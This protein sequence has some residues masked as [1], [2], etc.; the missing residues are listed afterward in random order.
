MKRLKKILIV[1]GYNVI[2]AWEDLKKLSE[3]NLEYAREKLNYVISEYAQFKGYK[4]IIVYDAYKVKDSV[5]RYEKIKNLEIVFTKEKE[6][7]DTYIER[8]ITE[9]GPKKFLDITVATDDIAEQQVVSGKGGNRIST[10]QLYIE[11]NNAQVKIQE[12]IQKTVKNKRNTLDDFLDKEMI[13][14]LND[15]RKKDL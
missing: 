7:A 2:N 10:R 9:L 13:E 8:Y 6:T 5:T 4:T 15:M 14:K 1:D 3:E 12:K 11:V